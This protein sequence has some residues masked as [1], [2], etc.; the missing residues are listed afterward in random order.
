MLL[1]LSQLGKDGRDGRDG[2]PGQK[3]GHHNPAFK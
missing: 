1:A 2:K 3:V